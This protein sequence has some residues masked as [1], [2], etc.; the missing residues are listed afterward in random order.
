MKR[1]L[2]FITLLAVT[3]TGAIPPAKKEK[4]TKLFDGKSITGWHRYLKTDTNGWRVDNGALTTDGKQGDLLT[5]KEYENFDLEFE[6]KVQAKGNS[7]V[8]YKVIEDA[9]YNQ[10]Y[11]SGPEFQVIDDKGYEWRDNGKL[12]KLNDN[13]LT[14]ANYDILPPN[15]LSVVKSAGDWNKGRILIQNNHV[16]HWLNGKKV[17]EYEYG[18]DAWKSM[19]AKSK[20]SKWAYATPHAKGK[21]ALQGHGDTVWYRG[22]R[23]REL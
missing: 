2:L 6:F 4:W 9:Q 20:F 10:P 11:I 23:I 15:D 5:D 18:S 3:L 22:I 14:G 12:M 7:G 16:E 13:Q 8:I 1:S 21:I 17:V 19:V